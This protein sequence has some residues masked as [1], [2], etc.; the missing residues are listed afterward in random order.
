MTKKKETT[1]KTKEENLVTITI[2]GSQVKVDGNSTVL[3]ACKKLGIEIPN[4]CYHERLPVLGKC[5]ICVVEIEGARTLM[6]SC[7]TKVR[8]GMIVKTNTP[9]VLEA[10]KNTLELLLSNHDLRCTT[11]S[12]NLNCKLQTYAEEFNIRDIKFPQTQRNVPLDHSSISIV[13][14]NNKC[15]L[16]ERC[17]SVC[18]VDQTVRAIGLQ[19]RGF[20]SIIQ[21]PFGAEVAKSNC[22]DCGQCVMLCPVGALAIKDNVAEVQKALSDPKKFVVVQTAPSVRVSISEAMGE[23][24]GLVTT[25]KM[26]TA[27]REVGFDKVYDTNVGADMTIVEEATEFIE[28]FTNNRDMPM[29]TSCCPGWVKFVE[30]FYPD[31]IKHLSSCKS[32]Q[33]MLSTILSQ[34][35]GKNLTEDKREIIVVDIMPCT[36]KKA[37][38]E[39]VKLSGDCDFVLTTV[40]FARLMKQNNID[41]MSLPDSEFDSP[42]GQSTGAGDI[43]ARSG[44]VMEAALRTAADFLEE[45]NLKSIDYNAVRGFETAKEATVKVAGKEIK[46]CVVHTLNQA[47]KVIEMVKNG[48]C[49]YDFIEVMACYGGCIG[50]GGQPR[51]EEKAVVQARANA[52]RAVDENKKVRKSHQNKELNK[53]YEEHFDGKYGSKKAHHLLHTSFIK[54][55]NI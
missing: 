4:L 35:L 9:R 8:E 43:F 55:D 7:N 53:F 12:S 33:A 2:N 11:C 31:Q 51:Y 40:E 3:Q 25:G 34:V 19:E 18:N 37:E 14:D 49:P 29:F 47:R 23:K 24:P 27:L 13:R 6:T 15:I 32:P 5:R 16:C 39:R 46:V 52:V 26:V 21:S 20:S 22:V 38:V 42:F 45:K 48:N 54:R 44:G 28:R 17:V 30:K 50:G 41:Y 1:P 36:A 10:R